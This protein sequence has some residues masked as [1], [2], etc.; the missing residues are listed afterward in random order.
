MA[1]ARKTT[2]ARATKGEHPSPFTLEGAK[3]YGPIIAAAVREALA[4][5]GVRVMH[6]KFT[7]GDT[8]KC[9]IE[10]AGASSEDT[11][12]AQAYRRLHDVYGL[13]RDGLGKVIQ[14]GDKTFTIVGLN[15]KKR[16][17]RGRPPMVV[18]MKQKDDPQP[19]RRWFAD[20]E[21][22]KLMLEVQKDKKP[23]ATSA[24]ADRRAKKPA[25]KLA[26][27]GKKMKPKTAS[28]KRLKT[29]LTGKAKAPKTKAK[30]GRRYSTF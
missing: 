7:Y 20:A 14:W 22:I 19:T 1:K 27:V 15:P 6:H 9:M 21:R 25:D 13:P 17:K 28:G 16:G 23:A 3:L 26:G 2:T 24:K 30:P 5:Y 12:E 8:A 11:A 29:A 18:V 4:E 10:L